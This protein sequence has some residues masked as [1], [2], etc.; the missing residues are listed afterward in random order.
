MNGRHTLAVE[1]MLRA[2][3]AA[4]VLLCRARSKMLRGRIER[5][6]TGDIRIDRFA[7]VE[8]QLHRGP[9]V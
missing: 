3:S 2:H 7:Y 6:K 5:W 1:R 8:I 9:C 4:A